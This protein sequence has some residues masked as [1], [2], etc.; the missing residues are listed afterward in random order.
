MRATGGGRKNKNALAV[1]VTG[2]L[3]KIDEPDGLRDDNA[4][5]FW[6]TYSQILIERSQLTLDRA[7]LLMIYCNSLSLYLQAEKEL[8]ED[9]LTVFSEMGGPKKNPKAAVRQDAISSVT[10]LGSLFGFDP[11]S[12]VRVLGG[13]GSKKKGENAFNEF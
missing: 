7:P 10:R 9:G 13:S 8:G 4:I 2:A 1:P 11:L 6:E 12:A 3:T 5:L